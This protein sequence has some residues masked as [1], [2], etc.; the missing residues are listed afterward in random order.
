MATRTPSPDR[1]LL[2]RFNLHIP[3]DTPIRISVLEFPYRTALQDFLGPFKDIYQHRHHGEKAYL[4]WRQLSSAIM[5]L[6]PSLIH[7][8]EGFNDYKH[9]GG[10]MATFTHYAN[11]IPQDFPRHE[12]LQAL[13]KLWLELWGR[14]DN[15]VQAILEGDGK[16][17]WEKL[18]TAVMGQPEY[19]WNAPITPA[20]Y[21]SD[22]K[23]DDGMAYAA[24]PSLITRLLHGQQMV[25]QITG[26]EE[27][28]ITWRR[29]H[30][31]DKNGVH[32]VSQPILH[33][34]DYYSYRL[35]F[36][37][38][39]QSGRLNQQGQLL[40]WIFAHLSIQ[41]YV[42]EPLRYWNWGR[43]ISILVG[44]NREQ[45]NGSGWDHDTTLIRL[46]V[47]RKSDSWHWKNG[48]GNLLNTYAIR[49]LLP[50]AVIIQDPFPY[51]QFDSHSQASEDE[52]RIVYAEGYKFGTD[53]RGHKHRIPTGMT[54]Y[55]RSSILRGV[56][57]LLNGWLRV[58]T[59]LSIDDHQT[60]RSYAL[61]DYTDMAKSDKAGKKHAAWLASL[62]RSLH[63]NNYEHLH[64]AVLHRTPDFVA[65]VLPILREVLLS[66][67]EDESPLVTITPVPISPLLSAPLDSN[68][69]D[70][71]LKYDTNRPDHYFT[72]WKRQ[73]NNSFEAKRGLWRDFLRTIEWQPNA[74]RMVLIDSA[75]M[76]LD[77]DDDVEDGNEAGDEKAS[78]KRRSLDP[79]LSIKGSVRDACNREGIGSQ[80]LIGHFR[81]GGLRKQ[82]DELSGASEGRIRNASLD[83]ILRQQGILYATPAEIYANAAGLDLQIAARLDVIAL[84]RLQVYKPDFHYAV[85]VRLRA[86]SAVQVMLPDGQRWL[87]YEEAAYQVG[88]KLSEARVPISHGKTPI[89]LNLYPENL[90]EFARHVLTQPF[91]RPT[92]AVIQAEKWRN[93]AKD[94]EKKAGWTQLKNEELFQ[95]PDELRFTRFEV[96]PRSADKL[97]NLLGVVRLRMDQETPQYI[98]ADNFASEED[99]RDIPHL[100]GYIDTQ[101]GNLF[102]YFS[103]AGLSEMQRKAGQDH[104]GNRKSFKL[105]VKNSDDDIP[106]KHAQLVEMVPFF[107]RP[108]FQ[109]HERQTQLC[110]CLHHLRI[111][112]GFTMGDI[113]LT[114]PMHIGEKLIEDQLC[115]INA[116]D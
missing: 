80:F 94:D 75:G 77:A 96:Y 93:A 107:V 34:G 56:L 82:S 83:L 74:R 9:V 88:Q 68:G 72:K 62:R 16:P 28:E 70:P 2:T 113:V 47:E 116:E 105:D 100:T 71:Q 20:A 42:T 89:Y 114:Y 29:A 60:P 39:T 57:T 26:G 12:D 87:T 13:I 63:H 65:N 51:A 58:D 14:S 92:L 43:D 104:K 73:I 6:A 50:P 78:A 66:A 44:N 3:T 37:V 84:C 1:I 59:P 67:N 4:P 109:S 64:I 32:L 55:E 33:S 46:P 86:D 69:L 31:G 30:N 8:F 102:H 103:V 97:E 24:L 35:D 38:E 25:V 23:R 61:Y 49:Q 106:Y 54:L 40:P 7:A 99:M 98:S 79:T 41:R 27:I 17:H 45:F 36:N 101:S 11:S 48:I 108:D 53:K 115:I 18:L 85:A 81:Y 19:G 95:S 110:R 112:P 91:D 76:Q 90:R 21:L 10:R 52:Y 5:A 15:K 111:S 22:L